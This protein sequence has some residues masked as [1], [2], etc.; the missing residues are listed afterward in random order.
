[1]KRGE[2]ATLGE[3]NNFSPARDAD[4]LLRRVT[5]G[6]Q[7]G[8]AGVRSGC[9]VGLS[10][11]CRVVG[12]QGS[13]LSIERKAWAWVKASFLIYFILSDTEFLAQL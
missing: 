13:Q 4:N 7:Q 9:T 3:E 10:N 12:F 2:E 5:G 6:L 11:T 8:R 1:M